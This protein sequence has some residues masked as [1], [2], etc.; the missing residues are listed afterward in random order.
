MMLL[1]LNMMAK[2]IDEIGDALEECVYCRDS[3]TK[4]YKHFIDKP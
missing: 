1:C 3:I 2:N 4:L